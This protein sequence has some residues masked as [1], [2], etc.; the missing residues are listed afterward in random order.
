MKGVLKMVCVLTSICVVSALGLGYVYTKAKPKIEEQ[1]EEASRK[2]LEQVLPGAVKFADKTLPSLNYVEGYGADGKL[3]GYAFDGEAKGYS[4]T[5]VV[6]VGL[7]PDNNILAIKI[8]QQQETP[9]LGTK[10]VDVPVEET[11][12]DKLRGRVVEG[13]AT[14]SPFQ[15]QFRGKG[16]D[17]L[18]LVRGEWPPPHPDHIDAITGATIT[19]RAV[20]DAVKDAVELFLKERKDEGAQGVH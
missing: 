9:G 15:A 7:S 2:A 17:D 14:E 20:T 12:W 16:P 19:S 3:V 4:S 10:A 18:K 6:K 5:I 11:L 8:L 1:A 13:G